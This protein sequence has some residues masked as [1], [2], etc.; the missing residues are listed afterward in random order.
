MQINL[1]YGQ[2]EP[3]YYVEYG[4]ASNWRNAEIYEQMLENDL[5]DDSVKDL[6]ESSLE[7]LER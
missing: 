5:V 1:D 4:L 6:L 2:N 3:D 7:Q